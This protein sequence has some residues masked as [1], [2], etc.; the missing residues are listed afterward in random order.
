MRCL[1]EVDDHRAHDDRRRLHGDA[2]VVDTNERGRHLRRF[3][4]ARL[5][6]VGADARAAVSV[7]MR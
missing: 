2:R 5:M 3:R 1:V 7:R 6:L 4:C